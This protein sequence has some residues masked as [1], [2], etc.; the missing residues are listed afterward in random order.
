MTA[1]ALTHV[2]FWPTRGASETSRYVTR[3]TEQGRHRLHESYSLGLAAKGV[4]DDLFSVARECS[5]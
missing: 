2:G 3:Q 5:T 4:F 1:L